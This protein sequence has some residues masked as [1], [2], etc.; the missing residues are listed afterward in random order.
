M[1]AQVGFHLT[2]GAQPLILVPARINGFGPYPFVL[3]T[4]AG[5]CLVAP[6]LARR[7]GVPV[8]KWQKAFA[9]GGPIELG[10]G[11]LDSLELGEARVEG[12]EAAVT[13]ELVRI[14]KAVRS[15][16]HGGVG[17]PFLRH[18][19]VSIDY[20]AR[21]LSLAKPGETAPSRGDAGDVAFRIAG[22]DKPLVLV[23]AR[24]NGAAPVTFALDTG[25]SST[26]IS[27]ELAE[28]FGIL[29]GASVAMM[30]GGGRVAAS[31]GSLA[32]LGVGA[33]SRRFLDV[34]VADFLAPLSTAIG[35]KVEG[36]LGYNF[37][38][39][40]RVTID[41]PAGRLRLDDGDTRSS[42]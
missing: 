28:R 7:A 2:G 6:G 5:I 10:L 4:G 24:I 23:Q 41:Y 9:A 37:L 15:A 22:A 3:D 36:I 34:A 31:F 20:R 29:R 8:T 26:V 39:G 12:V 19:R 33:A 27:P 17:Y 16:V 32:S 13:R 18:F 14:G 21:V 30:G 1:T 42:G 11:R 25:A 38:S 35:E 40:F